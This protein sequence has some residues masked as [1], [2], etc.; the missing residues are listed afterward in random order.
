MTSTLMND[1]RLRYYVEN[2]G[3]IVNFS[4][5][6]KSDGT[7]SFGVGDHGYDI[8]VLPDYREPDM[9]RMIR[10]KVEL[11]PKNP[12]IALYMIPKNAPGNRI[13][14]NPHSYVLV[15]S[16]E[17]FRMPLNVTAY[18][19]GKS[20][21]SRFGVKACISPI[22][23]GFGL[24]KKDGSPNPEGSPISFAIRNPY[25]I[26]VVVYALEGLTQ[27]VFYEQSEDAE[28]GY[29]GRYQGDTGLTGSK[30]NG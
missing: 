21:Y 4:E 14:I 22:D 27:L 5:K 8:R 25:P 28:Q 23:A 20:T 30:V 15:E 12:E 2:H 6:V 10:D 24:T 1:K 17:R 9:V 16:V 7:I 3:M 29:N 18:S 19:E 26:P 11:D 13:T